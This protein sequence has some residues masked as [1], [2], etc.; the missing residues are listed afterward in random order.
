MKTVYYFEL[1][2]KD[3]VQYYEKRSNGMYYPIG[4]YSTRK[5]KQVFSDCEKKRLP[6][7]E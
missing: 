6:C 2:H 7:V 1:R 4:R 5:A 3:E